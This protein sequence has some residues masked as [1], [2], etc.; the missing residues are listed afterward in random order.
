[1]DDQGRAGATAHQAGIAAV[2][3]IA[4]ITGFAS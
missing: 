1:L 3:G 2:A 4:A